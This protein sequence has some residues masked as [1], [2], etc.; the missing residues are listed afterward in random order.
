MNRKSHYRTNVQGESLEN[1]LQDLISRLYEVLL[2]PAMWAIIVIYCWLV[3]LNVI[4]INIGASILATLIFIVLCIRTAKRYKSISKDI[5]NC[6]K[7]LDGERMVGGMLEKLTSEKDFV[8]H[9]IICKVGKD[10]KV[11]CNIDHVIV[12]TKGI[13]AIDTKNKSL[14]DREYD[15][16]DY[17]FDDGFLVDCTGVLQKRMMDQID[18]EASFLEK[19]IKDWIGANYTV[20]RSCVIIGAFVKYEQNDFSKYWFVNEN[21]FMT[22][23]EKSREEIPLQDVHRIS[24]NLRRYAEKVIK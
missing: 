13:F 21:G 14:L 1:R 19:K 23:F 15:Q 4:S 9:D 3:A 24:D 16:A 12:S 7:G 2:F 22:L 10:E 20:K 17:T 18:Y 11:I 8:F 6:R 5:Q